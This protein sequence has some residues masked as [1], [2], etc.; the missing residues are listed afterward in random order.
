MRAAFVVPMFWIAVLWVPAGALWAAV[1]DQP[2]LPMK[3]P[4]LVIK[5][6][7]VKGSLTYQG[8][9]FTNW[10]VFIGDF[11]RAMQNRTTLVTLD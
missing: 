4:V 9:P 5:Y 1:S 7:P 8:R 11:D 10:W 6:F 2:K 3:L